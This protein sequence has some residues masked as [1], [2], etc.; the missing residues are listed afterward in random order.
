MTKQEII[1]GLQALGLKKG[2]L[3]LLHSSL[4]SL[5][6]VEGGP[7]A[8]IDA[9]LETVGTEGTLMVPVFGNLGILT[10]T[11]QN[12]PG[13]ITSP[14]PVGTV[15][16]LGKDAEELCRDHWKP[17]SCHGEG[18]PFKRLADKGGYVCLMGV[19]QD[20]N[21]SLHG[22]EAELRLAYLGSTT[23]E[24]T[25]PEGDTI[26]KTWKYYPGPHRDFIAIDHVLKERGFLKQGRIGNSQVR[27]IQA[28]GMW[29]CGMELGSADPAFILCDN[30]GCKDC[31]R[32][33]AAL[34]SDFFSK[35][36]FKLT[37]SS[38]LAG[39]YIPEMVEKCKAAGVKYVE[40]DFVQGVPAASM[41]AEKLAAAVAELAADGIEVSALRAFA[42]PDKAEDF[43]AKVKGAGITRVILPLSSSGPAAAACVEQGIAVDF[44]NANLTSAA[45]NAALA[46]RKEKIADCGICFNPANFVMAGERAFTIYRT[47]RFIKVMRQLDINDILPDG[48]VTA[49]ARGGAEIKEMISIAR[50]ASFSGFMCLAG[51]IKV[52][53][54]LKTMGADFRK[55]I[56][57]M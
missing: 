30:P 22:I 31:V 48:T 32:Q 35:E 52:E 16:A 36:D 5:G 7:E 24:Y 41:S 3:V 17:E 15:A 46:R 57:N 49:L 51:G 53:Q 34:M 54:D 26:N 19:D 39:R 43:A 47:G 33:R 8:V 14:C 4:Y 56:E 21:T 12:R 10:S 44:F 1:S 29:E 38:R 55:L 37:A 6:H 20:R 28:K 27:L 40:L 13:A 2:D 25:T 11:L 50:C 45:T 9:F 18:T 23:R 42:A